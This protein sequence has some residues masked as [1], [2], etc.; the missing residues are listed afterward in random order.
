MHDKQNI[1]GKNF[2]ITQD[3]DVCIFDCDGCY[4]GK[5]NTISKKASTVQFYESF[6]IDSHTKEFDKYCF[7][8][9]ILQILSNYYINKTNP[10]SINKAISNLKINN[11][12]LKNYFQI[13]LNPTIE[14]CYTGEILKKTKKCTL[15]YKCIFFSTFFFDS[16]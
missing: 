8:L 15:K 9:M 4:I 7:T 13:L 14:Q 11:E 16:I 10:E 3:N 5:K 12:S 1:H 2:E 6:G